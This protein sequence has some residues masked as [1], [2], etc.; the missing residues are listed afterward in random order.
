MAPFVNVANNIIFRMRQR[1]GTCANQSTRGYSININRIRKLKALLISSFDRLL[2]VVVKCLRSVDQALRAPIF[3]ARDVEAFGACTNVRSATCE[4]SYL[5][6]I[7]HLSTRWRIGSR[8]QMELALRLV[9]LVLLCES[10]P[11]RQ[12]VL[13]TQTTPS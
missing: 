4:K 10:G 3:E 7:G 8:E 9:I 2:L 12:I 5:Q 13:E 6:S 11:L 1:L